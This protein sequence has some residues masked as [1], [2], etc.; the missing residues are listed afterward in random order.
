MAIPGATFRPCA[1]RQLSVVDTITQG[2]ILGGK[3]LTII[4]IVI[5][6][7]VIL[8]TILEIYRLWRN[9]A[10]LLFLTRLQMIGIVAVIEI[11]SARS[12]PPTGL[13]ETS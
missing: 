8:D 2:V 9:Y 5:Y 1:K 3:P 4:D 6:S 7:T 11:V 13:Q 10:L 12:S